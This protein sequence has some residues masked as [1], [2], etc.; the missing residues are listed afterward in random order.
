MKTL[1]KE[2]V[3]KP[4]ASTVTGESRPDLSRNSILFELNEKF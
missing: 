1:L 4:E 2:T 3:K